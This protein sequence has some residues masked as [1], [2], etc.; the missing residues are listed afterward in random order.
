MSPSTPN[1]MI[2]NRLRWPWKTLK[3]ANSIVGSEPG[4]PITPE[5]SVSSATPARPRSRMT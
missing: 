1:T 2:P 3:P 4:M 5:V